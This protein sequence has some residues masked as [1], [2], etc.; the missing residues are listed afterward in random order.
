MGWVDKDNYRGNPADWVDAKTFVER[1]RQIMPI[2]QRNNERLLG[3]LRTSEA[4]LQSVEESLK[5][6]TTAIETLEQSHDE[7]TKAQVK[8]AR[9]ALQT[10]LT[11]ALRDGE[12][13]TA[14]E[15]TSKLSELSVAEKGEERPASKQDERAA[16]LPLHPEVKAWFEQNPDFI[17]NPRKVALGNAITAEF[18]AAGDTR[19]GAAFLDAIAAEVDKTLGVQRRGGASR[20]EGDNGGGGRRGDTGGG[21]KTYADLPAEAKAICDKQAARLVGP[22]RA[23]KDV[24]SWRKS[25]ARQYFAE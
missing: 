21:A 10:E 17:K 7:D 14:A 11:T 16:S 23:H 6:A 8:A 5:A 15:L 20:V 18:R 13:A 12:H 24:E 9:E 25:Y 22:T 3:Q 19:T 4:R 1:G 2:L